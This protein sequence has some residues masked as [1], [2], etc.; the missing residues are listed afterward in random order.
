MNSDWPH[1][2]CFMQQHFGNIDP[3]KPIIERNGNE[4]RLIA[5]PLW[6]KEYIAELQ[7]SNQELKVAE[8]VQIFKFV[9]ETKG[10]EG[11]KIE[12]MGQMVHPRPVAPALNNGFLGI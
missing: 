11:I 7:Q 3:K 8:P 5:H 6:S 10:T 1:W 12:N 4:I 9:S 2:S